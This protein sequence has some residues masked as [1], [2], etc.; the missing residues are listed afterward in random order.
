[1][2]LKV[3]ENIAD[4]LAR[5]A[6]ARERAEKETNRRSQAEWF[7][8]EVRWMKLI[9]S[10]RFVEQLNLFLDDAARHRLNNR[11]GGAGLQTKT[12]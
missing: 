10:F 6:E 3:P 11:R 12:R 1:M 5:A 2:L 4:C 8:L 7:A 9:E